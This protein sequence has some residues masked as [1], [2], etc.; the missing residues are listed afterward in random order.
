[1]S[2]RGLDRGF[3]LFRLLHIAVVL[4]DFLA[5]GAFLCFFDLLLGCLGCNDVRFFSGSFWGFRGL[6]S[7]LGC[8]GRDRL[9]L[10]F[11]PRQ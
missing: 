3:S 7:L 1:M 8:F 6:R 4:V 5:R 9:F 10:G 11:L 2:R